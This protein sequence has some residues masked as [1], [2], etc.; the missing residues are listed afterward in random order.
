MQNIITV[1]IRDSSYLLFFQRL[2]RTICLYTPL[3]IYRKK[4]KFCIVVEMYFKCTGYLLD[5]CCTDKLLKMLNSQTVIW[6]DKIS[7]LLS[8]SHFPFCQERHC[9]CTEN[10]R[11]FTAQSLWIAYGDWFWIPASWVKK[12]TWHQPMLAYKE[13]LMPRMSHQPFLNSFRECFI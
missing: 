7:L 5:G 10:E 1:H 2:K 8:V 3:T 4:S 9:F 6:K 11:L 12:L 13:F